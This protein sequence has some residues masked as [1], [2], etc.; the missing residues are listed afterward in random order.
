MTVD[1]NQM[2]QGK[3]RPL[4]YFMDIFF[5]GLKTQQFTYYHFS[6]D[7]NILLIIN[8]IDFLVTDDKS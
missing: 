7:T 5:F 1:V 6:P 4:S 3:T 2:K 8:H